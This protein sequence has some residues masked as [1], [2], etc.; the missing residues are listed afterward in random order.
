MTV[1]TLV[2]SELARLVATPLARLA[3]VALMLVPVLY[4]GLYL[5]AN[6]DPYAGL[7]RVPAALV[8]A[9][10][11]TE[12]RDV[13]RELQDGKAFDWHRVSA[14]TA[15]AGVESGRYDF[16]I[17]LPAGFSAS[18]DSLDGAHP[19]PATIRLVTNDTNGYLSSTIAEQ[20]TEKVRAAIAKKVGTE[21]AG[22][23]L[24]AL[25][26]IRG[27]LQ[28]A[29][30][31]AG[32][33]ADGATQAES[34]AQQ[35]ADG[36]GS[37]ASGAAAL[38]S[39]AG[40]LAD[41]TSR[42]AAG[43]SQVAAGT[44]QLAAKG[45]QAAALGDQLAGQVPTLRAQL[46]QQLA[47]QG[48]TPTQVDTIL[49]D[50]DPLAAKAT[51]ANGQLQALSG[52]VDQLAAGAAQVST[53]ASQAASGASALRSGA[54]Q[55][56]SGAAQAHDGATQLSGGL[57]SLAGGATQLRDG[58]SDGVGRIPA[59]TAAQR[60]AQ[61]TAIGDPAAVRQHADTTAGGYGAGLAPFFV[62][63][64]AWIGIYALFLIVKPISRRGLSAV[65]RPVRITLAAWLTPALLGMLQMAMV[66]AV[67]TLGL[68]FSIANPA[69]TFLMM[70]LA[71]ATFSAIILAL[72][73]WLSSVGQFLGLVLMVV[74]LVT[75]GGTFPWQTLPGPL[76]ALHPV[77]P[78]SAAVD[79][80]RRLMYGGSTLTALGDAG[81]LALW[82]AGAL[83][84]TGIAAVR[85]TH[86]R[87]LRDLRPSLI[88]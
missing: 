38:S 56:A 7:D 21:A 1:L 59:R 32:R 29:A 34:G 25:S 5:W 73:V 63:L 86:R 36:T 78:M 15:A 18:L 13:A 17:T 49:A 31:G 23:F 75:A 54:S 8:V 12:A 30:D 53:G 20:A 47:D 51:A 88:G 52:Q 79:G 26:D 55:V 87:T 62:S 77:L 84:A 64:A 61:A 67:L 16:S 50:L 76:A 19:A 3:L 83:L 40:T 71:S 22:R 37:L 74:Q 2:R 82:L 33:L 39:G 45:D 72:N 41:G 66:F 68:G 60:S 11:G 81:A 10:H 70:A 69:G 46:A 58:L 4:G 65:D 48:L 6:R 14:A 80:L 9:D 44:Q 57:G 42:V 24:V 28:T 85:M 35:L 27:Q 43:A